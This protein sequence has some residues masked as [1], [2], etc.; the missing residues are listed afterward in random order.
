M[1]RIKGFTL[2]ELLVVI[3]IIAILL[4]ILLPVIGAAREQA[5]S[6]KCASNIRQVCQ[7][8]LM[9]AADHKDVLAYPGAN[10]QNPYP[11]SAIQMDATGWYNYDLGTLW[12]YVAGSASIRQSLFLRPSDDEPRFAGLNPDLNGFVPD[13]QHPRNFTYNFNL[14]LAMSPFGSL[15]VKTANV[16]YPAH[17]LMV[18]EMQM[19]WGPTGRVVSLLSQPTS[20][21]PPGVGLL[22]RRHRGACNEGFFDGHVE[23][24]DPNLFRGTKTQGGVAIWNEAY[25]FYVY[26]GTDGSGAN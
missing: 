13:P 4:A 19:P 2:V 12:P 1:R 25:A 3:G 22:S 26:I 16:L 15:N 24:I 14:Y 7:A 10:L 6:V 9:Y 23:R 17:K 20:G 18:F 5:R 11:Y 8:M 21:D